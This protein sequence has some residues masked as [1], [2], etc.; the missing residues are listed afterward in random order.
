MFMRTTGAAA[1]V[2]LLAT[3]GG[4]EEVETHIAVRY[5]ANGG[6]LDATVS[7]GSAE[8]RFEGIAAGVTSNFQ[9]A[10]F[11]S[12]ADLAVRVGNV[13]STVDLTEGA[14]N[15]IDIDG[16]GKVTGVFVPFGG[17]ET[18]GGW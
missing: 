12:L 13:T 17:S 11:A 14:S 2:F 15:I 8:L 4:S 7:D 5:V 3:C 6:L 18:G 1:L 10:T 9:L 16:A